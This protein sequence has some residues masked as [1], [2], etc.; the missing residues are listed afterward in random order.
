MQLSSQGF[1]DLFPFHIEFDQ[2][3][4]VCTLGRSLLKVLPDI[5]GQPLTQAFR[6]HRPAG[7][8]SWDKLVGNAAA[9]FI[10]HPTAKPAMKLRGQIVSGAEHR[11]AC[12]VGSP[13]AGRIEELQELSLELEDFAPFD[14]IFDI[15]WMQRAYLMAFEDAKRLAAQLKEKSNR[16][17]SIFALS[18]DGFVAFGD[19]RRLN[20]VNPAFCAMLDCQAKELRHI[21]QQQFITWLQARTGN[22]LFTDL[23][24]KPLLL[25]MR[26]PN[27]RTLSA[28]SRQTPDGTHIYYFRDVTRET[29]IDRLKSEFLTTAAHELRTPM[30]SIFGFVELMIARKFP[31]ERQRDMLETIHRQAKLMI[32]L[33]NELLDLARIEAGQG[34]DF[35][36]QPHRL[37]P[38]IERS[39][40]G[41][42]SN[43]H[44]IEIHLDPSIPAVAVDRDKM[45]LAV[46]NILSNAKKY[47]PNGGT[48]RVAMQRDQ[49]TG[50]IG[51]T[52]SDQGI[53]MTEEQLS[54]VFERF[55]RADPSQ[56]IP[57]TGLGMTIVREILEAHQGEVEIR[58]VWQSGT[59]VTLWLPEEADSTRLRAPPTAATEY[60]PSVN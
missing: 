12:F 6:I 38:I 45:Q 36:F 46:D 2:E 58:S 4:R 59:S 33:V 16:L 18:P 47:S 43:D 39:L 23:G 60:H 54:H 21:D 20:F 31:E 1:A 30:V 51:I 19:D 17:N 13:I 3:L 57:G 26:P 10:M 8:D 49:D 28:Q 34:R 5:L 25:N 44:Q 55:Y 41:F 27:Q 14:P 11:T 9:T 24:S 29:E 22:D 48:I 40:A 50:R 15:L 32:G 56:H 7:C 35:Q 53:G 42:L 37:Q 52:V